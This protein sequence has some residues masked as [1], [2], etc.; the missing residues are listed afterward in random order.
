MAEEI[1]GW[2]LEGGSRSVL[3]KIKSWRVAGDTPYRKNQWEETK[4]WLLYTPSPWTA[5]PLHIKWKNQ[6]ASVP[7]D[8]SSQTAWE[9]LGHQVT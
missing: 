7:P 1:P 6:R 4:P 3:P 2:W 9:D 8:T 5:S